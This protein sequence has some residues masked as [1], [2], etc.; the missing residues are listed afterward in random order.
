M[1]VAELKM[2]RFSLG[3]TKMMDN[4]RIQ[5]IIGTAPVGQFGE[6]IREARKDRKGRLGKVP[7]DRRFGTIKKYWIT[8]LIPGPSRRNIID[9]LD[10]S[11]AGS[12]HSPRLLRAHLETRDNILHLFLRHGFGRAYLVF[13][14]K[15]LPAP[16][17]RLMEAFRRGEVRLRASSARLSRHSLQSESPQHDWLVVGRLDC[18]IH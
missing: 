16:G 7:T 14:S 10:I 2:L 13:W 8:K 6:K 5:F 15:A 18:W 1:E 17:R 4:I 9:S 3:V 11:D 12:M